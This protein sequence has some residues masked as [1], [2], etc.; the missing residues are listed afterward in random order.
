M[1]WLDEQAAQCKR[2]ERSRRRDFF[3]LGALPEAITSVTGMDEIKRA[4]L[5]KITRLAYDIADAMLKEAE[6]RPL[7]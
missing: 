4:D 1:N 5:P 7:R 6:K 3:A 2:R